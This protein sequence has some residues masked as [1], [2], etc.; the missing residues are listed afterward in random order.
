MLSPFTAMLIPLLAVIGYPLLARWLFPLRKLSDGQSLKLLQSLPAG[1]EDFVQRLRV[2]DTG[3]RICNAAVVGCLPGF[4]FVLVS[5][6]LFTQLSPRGV[7]AI[8]AHE[9]GHLKLW[10]VPMRI[11]IVFAG[12]ILGL[13]L[14]QQAEQL[15]AWQTVAQIGA[16]LATAGYMGLML[17]MVAP[18]LEFHADAYAVD[19][20]SR[21][22]GDR[23]QG[24]RDLT[25]ALSRLTLLSGV[26]PDQKTWLYPSFEERRQAILSQQSSPHFRHRLQWMLGIVLFSQLVLIVVG[27]L[28]VAN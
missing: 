5:D 1:N 27:I 10:H 18:L 12:G 13:A 26:R 9:M 20:L 24:V 21:Q 25:K 22:C 14:V 23:R 16:M 11:C 28:V 8:V 19:T 3:E 15:S 6:A 17:H 2:C 4:S 7:A